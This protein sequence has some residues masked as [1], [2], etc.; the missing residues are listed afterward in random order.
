MYSFDDQLD[1]LG[2]DWFT[3]KSQLNA[4]WTALRESWETLAKPYAL[5]TYVKRKFSEVYY[6]WDLGPNRP[7]REPPDFLKKAYLAWRKTHQEY[8]YIAQEP[9][10]TYLGSWEEKLDREQL[11]YNNTYNRIF[12]GDRRAPVP[13][14]RKREQEEATSPRQLNELIADPP[15]PREPKEEKSFLDTLKDDIG[16]YALIIGGG[17]LAYNIFFRLAEGGFFK[18]KPQTFKSS[19][20]NG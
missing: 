15:A 13:E 16:T 8:M 3:T 11:R 6:V 14:E 9:T 12:S 18:P 7:G 1:E 2:S 4:K 10:F 5:P 17:I 20:K 19:G